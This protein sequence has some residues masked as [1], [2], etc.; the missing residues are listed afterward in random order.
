MK[1]LVETIAVELNN[2]T[3]QFMRI[4]NFCRIANCFGFL[5]NLVYTFRCLPLQCIS[6]CCYKLQLLIARYFYNFL[7][8]AQNEIN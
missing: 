3:E 4:L 2:T 6:A 8:S 7:I 5:F 1:Q